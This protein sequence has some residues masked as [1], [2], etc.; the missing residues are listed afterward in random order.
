MHRLKAG[1][2]QGDPLAPTLFAMTV[3]LLVPMLR[4]EG[5]QVPVM[6]YADDLTLVLQV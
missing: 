1:T 6:L 5:L 4:H 2:R 3:A